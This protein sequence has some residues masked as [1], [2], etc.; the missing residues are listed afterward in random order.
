[1]ALDVNE[2]VNLF[3][4]LFMISIWACGFIAI[5][6]MLSVLRLVGQNVKKI[7]FFKR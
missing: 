3:S 2:A 5:T 7:R 6:Y 1:M 4:T